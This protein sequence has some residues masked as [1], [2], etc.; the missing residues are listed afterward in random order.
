LV[1]GIDPDLRVV[2]Y[3]DALSALAFIRQTTPDLII[4]DYL[5]PEMD[6]VDLIRR[7][8]STPSCNDVPI[9]VVTVSE[10]K[11]VRYRALDAGATDFLTRPIDP[12][13]CRT[14][15]R[16]LLTLRRQQLIISDR[17]AWLAEEVS[18]AT[19]KLVE[20]ERETLMRLARAGEYRDEQTGSHVARIAEY[21]YQIASGL[22]LPASECDAIRL[23]APMHDIGKIGIPDGILRKPG[24]L[25][26][27]EWALMRQHTRIGYE[28]LRDSASH[29]LQLGAN[30]ALYHH[31]RMD[32]KGYPEGLQQAQIPIE[33]RIVAVADI[34]DALT[35]RR[36]YKPAWSVAD[37]I[38]YIQKA[39]GA[40]L[41]PDC[42]RAFMQRLPAIETARRSHREDD[43]PMLSPA[44]GADA[45]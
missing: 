3:S 44:P 34:F 4:T 9:I 25:T 19:S 26:D 21:C 14:R 29:Y 43:D 20:R 39:A 11:A 13:E 6:G 33:A 5:M 28:I 1:R 15:C 27:T 12:K 23:A 35:S 40:A 24:K 16:N 38:D 42:V 30:I 7:V 32:G 10:E 37:A 41:D 22:D 17:A 36:P 2:A 45:R 18:F 31:E 8:R